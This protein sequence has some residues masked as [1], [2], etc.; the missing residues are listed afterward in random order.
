MIFGISDA[1]FFFSC[2]CLAELEKKRL[3]D[4]KWWINW[5]KL[6]KM[7]WWKLWKKKI[8]WRERRNKNWEYSD[9]D[10]EN[11]PLVM[12]TQGKIWKKNWRIIWKNSNIWWMALM[13]RGGS[14]GVGGGSSDNDFLLLPGCCCLIWKSEM[15]KKRQK[16]K[17]K[18]YGRM[19]M[20]SVVIERIFSTNKKN[21]FIR[22]DRYM[23]WMSVG[24]LY[25]YCWF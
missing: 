8:V 19:M 24:C 23:E 25:R 22:L 2:C 15:E 10:E 16:W 9:D 5:K 11:F 3:F 4:E 12:H 1:F 7:R 14:S 6:M 13:K 17:T 21:S 18:I 20:V